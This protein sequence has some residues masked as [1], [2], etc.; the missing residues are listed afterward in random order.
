MKKGVNWMILSIINIMSSNSLN[1]WV[2]IVSLFSSLFFLLLFLIFLDKPNPRDIMFL[3]ILFK[4]KKSFIF[5]LLFLFGVVVIKLGH[6][7]K[8]EHNCLFLFSN[9]WYSVDLLTLA[10]GNHNLNF[11]LY[12]LHILQ[13][14]IKLLHFWY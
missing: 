10:I 1:Y 13:T 3:E 5:V 12:F 7:L 2:Q 8:I 14:K 4:I 11:L 9:D 6:F